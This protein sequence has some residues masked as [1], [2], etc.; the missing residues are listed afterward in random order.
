MTLPPVAS[1]TDGRRGEVRA[2]QQPWVQ[3]RRLAAQLHDDE[4]R[5][6]QE[7]ADQQRDHQGRSQPVRPSARP[8]S[9]AA[10]AAPSS[11]IPGTSPVGAAGPDDSG[12]RRATWASVAASA[13]ANQ[14]APRQPTRRPARRRA[15]VRPPCRC[16]ARAPQAARPGPAR[17]R[18][19]TPAR[20]CPGCTSGRPRR[21][22]P[23]RSARPPA[24]PWSGRPRRAPRRARARRR[25]SRNIRRRPWSSPA[26]PVG[27]R[28]E[29][30][31]ERHRAEDPG[32]A[33]RAGVQRGGRARQS[34]DRG[35]VHGHGEAGAR[36]GD[37][38]RDGASD[39]GSPKG[40]HAA[41][42]CRATCSRIASGLQRQSDRPPLPRIVTA[43]CVI[44][45]DI[46]APRGVL[47][48]GG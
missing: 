2:A 10:S 19:R 40:G 6:Q 39:G 23:A 7:P 35:D 20:P 24:R 25:R 16:R 31:A 3:H 48:S 21:P 8:A 38:Q 45:R 37:G 17:A 15:A 18:R 36:G 44:K 26:A 47:L 32:L 11:S 9:T 5:A 27:S 41:T 29:D 28:P 13:A 46:A 42:M 33:V 43:H 30:Q 34:G 22:G 4:R 14:Y 12:T 1:R